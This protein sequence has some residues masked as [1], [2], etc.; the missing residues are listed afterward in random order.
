MLKEFNGRIR[1]RQDT[2]TNWET[3]NPTL[4]DGELVI[5]KVSE[6][7]I[8]FKIGDGSRS[9]NNLPFQDEYIRGLITS[10]E[11]DIEKANQ[12]L[13]DAE[14]VADSISAN[15]T[16]AEEAAIK[17]E[18]ALINIGDSEAKA[19]ASAEKAESFSNSASQYA[20]TA[21]NYATQT[22]TYKNQAQ[23]YSYD[24]HESSLQAEKFAG[25]AND[26]ALLAEQK[27]N[28]ASE[29]AESAEVS[30]ISA[31]ASEDKAKEYSDITTV[32][33]D[34]AAKSALNASNKADEAKT[35]STLA[36]S[37]AQSAEDN[38]LKTQE[39]FNNVKIYADNAEES[40]NNAKVSENKSIESANEASNKSLLSQ[41]WAIGGTGIR[42]GEDT[43][44]AKYWSDLAQAVVEGGVTTFNGRFG[45]VVP[46]KGDYTAEMVGADAIGTAQNLI[47]EYKSIEFSL[48]LLSSEWKLESENKYY[49][50]VN[51]NLLKSENY[52]YLIDSDI[53][54]YNI[55]I[56]NK[57]YAED[58]STEGQIKFWS[59]KV[60][61]QNLIVNITRLRT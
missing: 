49:I 21:N 61:E 3:Y 39:T 30:Q 43:N 23:Q 57:I 10:V 31:K 48:T 34:E 25:N 45:N 6:K 40:A 52:V 41:S 9:Y 7:E 47:N 1:W 51:N 38:F 29:K 17:A 22:E 16:K 18:E 58:I 53:S 35:S 42:D 19:Q 56:N 44:N 28:L 12:I 36:Q 15:I 2:Q 11:S 14:A 54:N 20:N 37:Y 27:A 50:I 60:P 32:N 55:Y 33:K 5:V 59:I 13:Q 26:S 24:A 4:L 8:R 46:Q